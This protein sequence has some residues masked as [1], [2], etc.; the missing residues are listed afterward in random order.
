MCCRW[1][2]VSRTLLAV[3]VAVLLATR[4]V[5]LPPERTAANAT[6]AAGFGFRSEKRGAQ[7]ERAVL[8]S[9]IVRGQTLPMPPAPAQRLKQRRRVGVAAG[10]SLHQ[11]DACLLIGLLGAEQ[12]YQQARINLVQAQ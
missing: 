7:H 1:A 5:Q 4:D 9:M 8:F 6:S 12:T 3:T 11:V 10:L 2:A